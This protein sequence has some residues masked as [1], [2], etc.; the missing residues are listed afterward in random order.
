VQRT[1][2][3]TGE[4][5]TVEEDARAIDELRG[6]LALVVDVEEAGLAGCALQLPMVL[7]EPPSRLHHRLDVGVVDE[8]RAVAAAALHHRRGVTVEYALAPAAVD[9]TP[10]G[11]QERC[12]EDPRAL[13][14]P[15]LEGN[16]FVQVEGGAGGIVGRCNS[17]HPLKLSR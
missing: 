11:A 13:F 10:V 2:R 3:T 9:A 7:G 15:V 1:S 17:G 8:V 4:T 16:P 6:G 12:I 14:V 5:R